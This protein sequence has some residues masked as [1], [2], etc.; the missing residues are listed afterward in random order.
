MN[1]LPEELAHLLINARLSQARQR[2]LAG[3]AKNGRLETRGAA[4]PVVPGGW[5]GWL[6][7][8]RPVGD[9]SPTVASPQ[10]G[11]RRLESIL[12][13]VAER[14]VERGTRT[15]APTLCAMSAATRHLSPG[16][17]AALV[18]WDGS[19]PARLRAFGIVHGV[20][21]RDL[22]A[23]ACSRL[24]DELTGTAQPEARALSAVEPACVT[25]TAGHSA[26]HQAAGRPGESRGEA[27]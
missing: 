23:R 14:I 3:A 2:Q 18:D 9:Q 8:R 24:L 5:L 12:D 11:W 1:Y 6:L 16:A 26:A 15:E 10:P 21:L 4:Q 13:R 25:A 27:A 7:R 20:V 19:E 17:A 22:G